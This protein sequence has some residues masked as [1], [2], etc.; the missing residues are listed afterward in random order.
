LSRVFVDSPAGRAGLARGQTIVALDGRS[1][2]DIQAAEGVSAVLDNDVVEFTMRPLAGPDFSVTL[3]KDIVTIDPLP[4]WRI[5]DGSGGR[6][7]GYLEFATFISTATPGFE[8]IFAEFNAQN[9]TEV[10]IDLRYNGGGLVSTAE[11]LGDYLGGRIAT[12]LVFSSTEFNADRGPDNNSRTLF[13]QLGNSLNLTDLVVI[14]TRGTASASELVVNGLD[15]HTRVAI[16]GSNTFGKPVGQIGLELPG[17]CDI[18][19]RPTSFKTVNAVSF[20]EFFDGLP[21][22]CP[23]VDDLGVPVGVDTDPNMIAAL[24]YL[25]T[26]TCPLVAAPDAVNKASAGVE[27][28]SAGSADPRP[29][30]TGPPWREFADAY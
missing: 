26:G 17:G 7:I 13:T 8:T 20:G 5:I 3:T 10:I 29:E 30:L 15:P 16:V 23:A 9:V 19:L 24:G 2:A 25:E 21:V 28:P 4:Q 6:K 14:A 27:A 1:I 22:D 18:L 12:N 11:L